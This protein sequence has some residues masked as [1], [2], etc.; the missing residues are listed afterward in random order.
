MK[1]GTQSENTK[2]LDNIF[3][4]SKFRLLRF[5]SRKIIFKA[6]CNKCGSDDVLHYKSIKKKE[7]DIYG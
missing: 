5:S 7:N 6:R 2:I 4:M 1:D 3:D